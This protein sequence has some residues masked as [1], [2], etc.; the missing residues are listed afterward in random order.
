MNGGGEAVNGDLLA[1]CAQVSI[2][3]VIVVGIDAAAMHLAA[4]AIVGGQTAASIHDRVGALRQ[5]VLKWMTPV[6]SMT[7]LFL[8][9]KMRAEELAGGHSFATSTGSGVDGDS[10]LQEH[11]EVHSAEADVAPPLGRRFRH[12]QHIYAKLHDWLSR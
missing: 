1:T 3:A 10:T 6:V 9:I 4:R 7:L 11:N 12:A 2:A 8:R 5:V